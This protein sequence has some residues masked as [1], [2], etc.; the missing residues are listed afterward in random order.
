MSD[1]DVRQLRYFVA[2]AEELNF[3]RAAQRLGM[4]QPPLSK[5]IAQ[6]EHTLGVRLL[7]RSTRRVALTAAGEVLLAQARVALEA[8]NAAALRTQRAG[9]PE[10]RLVVT[11]KA[12]GDGGLL[13]EVMATYRAGPSHLPA[14]D[15]PPIEVVVGR[16]GEPPAMLRDGRA[17]VGFLRSPFELRGL[18]SEPLISEPRM[19]ALP[20]GHR[21]AARRRLQMSDLAGEPRARW[22]GLEDA[23]FNPGRAG[24]DEAAAR[25]V[26][27]G[28]IAGAG[29]GDVVAADGLGGVGVD[30]RRGE[31]VAADGLD[32][33][34]ARDGLDGMAAGARRAG[35]V[36]GDTAQL[37]EVVAL[38]QAIAFLPASARERQSRPD[39]VFRAVVGLSPSVIS[40][41]WPQA[42]RSRATAAFVRAAVEVAAR[43]SSFVESSAG[44]FIGAAHVVLGDGVNGPAGGV[45]I[46][47]PLVPSVDQGGSN[48]PPGRREL[49][50]FNA[51]SR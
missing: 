44:E 36:V 18:D 26:L 7:E 3:S 28:A 46:A 15:L 17:D 9:H 14:V 4:A 22:A 2:V 6:L 13:R 37:M 39:V 35:P 48:G 42:S 41:V 21:L 19:V 10:P 43:S 23:V 20:A 32:G 25:E 1:L 40:V 29:R 5:A 31:V 8:V 51:G 50:R 16:W 11:L 45:E 47:D 30:A 49:G 38:G 34:V 12:G 27:D 33:A 24:L